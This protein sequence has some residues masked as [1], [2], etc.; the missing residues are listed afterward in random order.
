MA[1][2]AALTNVLMFK[3]GEVTSRLGAPQVMPSSTERDQVMAL[4]A[5]PPSETLTIHKWSEPSG[6]RA[7]TGLPIFLT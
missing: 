6:A 5:Q 1:T 7:M 4:P 3:N 2:G